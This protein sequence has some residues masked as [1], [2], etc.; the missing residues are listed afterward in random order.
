MLKKMVEQ[1]LDYEKEKLKKRIENLKS[2]GM[3]VE[4]TPKVKAAAPKAAKRK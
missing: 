3:Y 1:G 2:K 4:R